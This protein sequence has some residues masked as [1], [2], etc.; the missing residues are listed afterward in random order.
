MPD[1]SIAV[2]DLRIGHFV[3]LPGSWKDHPFLFSSFRIKDE[4]QLQIIRNLGLAQVTIDP[5]RSTGDIPE[6]VTGEVVS[7]T[8]SEDVAPASAA[9]ADPIRQQQQD[10]RR[11]MRF[12]DRQFSNA[13]SP[14]RES[15]GQ[16]NLKPDEGLATV[17]QLI[18][19]AAAHLTQTEEPIGLQLV[20]AVQQGDVLLL[21][22][23]NTAYI[24]MLMAREAGWS[25]LEIENAGLAALVHDIGELKIPT[26]ISR[27]RVELTKSEINFMRMHVQ[28]GFDQLSQLKAFSPEIR[29]AV[30][31]HQERLDGSGYPNGLKGEQ[32]G[33]LA[34]LISVADYYEEHLHPRAATRPGQPNQ[35]VA[36]LFKKADVWFDGNFIKLL[37]K[38]LG[39]YPPGSL[40]R[41]SDE[42][43]A[44]VMA[45][46]PSA[47]LKPIVLPYEKGRVSEGV[48]LIP[49]Q[50]DERQIMGLCKLEE[51]NQAQ[52]DFFSLGKH[53]CYYFT[54]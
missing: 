54:S 45:S 27:K 46:E 31:Q 22:S 5:Y 23:L 41:L 20:R 24:A 33:T 42:T 2:T 26:Q 52:H 43:L 6:P 13:L 40:V 8:P 11:S 21:H 36:S 25:P 17:A 44:L 16:L 38:V 1:I 49:L 51:L 39:I 10:L 50:Q 53:F 28:Y 48:D 18:R 9:P 15:L 35:V 19:T 14:L 47:P 7:A 3:K 30:L 32:I 29:Q 34:R 12:A 37:I 4:E